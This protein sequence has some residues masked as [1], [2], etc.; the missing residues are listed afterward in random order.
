MIDWAID[1]AEM[2]KQSF[3]QQI[4]FEKLLN[5]IQKKG[6]IYRWSYNGKYI[7]EWRRDPNE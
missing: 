6:I 4:K 2:L 5:K 1:E 7:I 3:K